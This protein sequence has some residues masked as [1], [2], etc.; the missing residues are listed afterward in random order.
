MSRN[1]HFRCKNLQYA[2]I[3]LK[4][5]KK[6]YSVGLVHLHLLIIQLPNLI[7]CVKEAAFQTLCLTFFLL[8]KEF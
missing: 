5:W 6:K 1:V 4:I 7:N 8:A 3:L 2:N